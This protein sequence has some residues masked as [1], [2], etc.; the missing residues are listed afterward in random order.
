MTKRLY[1]KNMMP[2]DY[3]FRV[4]LNE[5]LNIYVYIAKK[6]CAG[7]DHFRHRNDYCFCIMIIIYKGRRMNLS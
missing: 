1:G 6:K 4:R 7:N 3:V 2:N 5:Y